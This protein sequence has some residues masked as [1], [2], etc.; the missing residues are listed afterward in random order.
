VVV[1]F[2][3]REDEVKVSVECV[4]GV[5]WPRVEADGDESDD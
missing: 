4:R 5:P 1:K 2:V 3:A